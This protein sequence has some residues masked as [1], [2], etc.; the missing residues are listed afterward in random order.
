MIALRERLSRGLVPLRE[1]LPTAAPAAGAA[2][3]GES[4]DANA[5][6]LSKLPPSELLLLLTGA[7]E[8]SLRVR[9]SGLRQR[10]I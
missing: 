1:Q 9:V 3:A 7:E 2:G 6:L 8:G 10:T 4:S 5:S